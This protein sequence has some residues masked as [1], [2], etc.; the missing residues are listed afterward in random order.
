MTYD[1]DFLDARR[2][3][4]LL[5]NHKGPLTGKDLLSADLGDIMGSLFKNRK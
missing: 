4:V 3:S 1:P 5:Q 2:E